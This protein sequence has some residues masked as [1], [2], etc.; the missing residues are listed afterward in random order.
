MKWKENLKIVFTIFSYLTG[1]FDD[2]VDV[3]HG[4]TRKKIGT[5]KREAWE[6]FHFYILETGTFDTKRV[7][8]SYHL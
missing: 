8:N 2:M 4:N 7:Q 5:N 6:T 1:H 3:F